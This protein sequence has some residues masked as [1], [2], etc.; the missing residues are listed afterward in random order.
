[1]PSSDYSL[2]AMPENSAAGRFLFV[3]TFKQLQGGGPVPPTRG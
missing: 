1:M 3:R 2:S